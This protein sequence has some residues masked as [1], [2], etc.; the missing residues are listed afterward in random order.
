MKFKITKEWSAKAT[1]L[2]DGTPIS[3]CSPDTLKKQK[4]QEM[5]ESL[6]E[7][8]YGVWRDA[9][10]THSSENKQTQEWVNL[11]PAEGIAWREVACACLKSYEIYL[12]MKYQKKER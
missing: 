2:E 4:R 5:E 9:M 3:A 6:A 12:K 8:A 11:T 10:N 7:A 1:K